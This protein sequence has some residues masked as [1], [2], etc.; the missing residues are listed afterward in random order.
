MR[1][2]WR[3]R[4]TPPSFWWVCSST[5]VAA[6]LAAATKARAAAVGLCSVM[7]AADTVAPGATART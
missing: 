4:M 3:M 6:G 7:K 5:V 1:S 2:T